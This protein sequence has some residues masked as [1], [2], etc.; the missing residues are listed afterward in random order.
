MSSGQRG[1][2]P[3]A[4]ARASASLVL[5]QGQYR[6]R[7]NDCTNALLENF[8]QIVQSAQVSGVMS[9]RFVNNAGKG[10]SNKQRRLAYSVLVFRVALLLWILS[11]VYKSSPH[12]H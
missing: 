7:L 3:S 9:S 4:A 10:A 5:S 11:S 6:Q 12:P 2:P 1:G 8:V